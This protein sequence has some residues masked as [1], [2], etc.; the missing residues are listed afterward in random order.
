MISIG[1]IMIVRDKIVVSVRL[2]TFK[3]V[4]NIHFEGFIVSTE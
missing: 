2:N 4:V 3:I 1:K